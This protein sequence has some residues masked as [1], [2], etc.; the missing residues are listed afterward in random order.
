MSTACD[1]T[2]LR[3]AD[4]ENAFFACMGRFFASPQVRRDCGGYALNDGPSF[5]WFAARRQG[6]GRVLGFISVEEGP[7]GLRIRQGY[8]C[9]EARGQGLFRELGRRV[10]CHADERNA[11]L[12]ACVLPPSLPF[13]SSLGFLVRSQRGSW[14]TVTRTAC[15]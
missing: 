8:V 11:A 10:L 2:V 12:T 15:E 7:A 4:D 9:P 3:S 1:F 5:H 14:T 13:L 6:D